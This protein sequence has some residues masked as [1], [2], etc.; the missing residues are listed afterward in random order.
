MKKTVNYVVTL[1]IFCIIAAGSLAFV[2]IYTMPQIN[3]LKEQNT[4]LAVTSVIPGAAEIK[5]EK[6]D[7]QVYFIGMKDGK[8]IGIAIKSTPKGYSAPIQMLVG[9]DAQGNVSGIAI[10]DQKETPGLGANILTKDFK[11]TGK[12]FVDQFIGKNAESILKANQDID[13]LTGATISTNAVC[14]GVRTALKLKQE[15]KP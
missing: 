5:E 3:R 10:L 11:G 2:Y 4:R 9:I 12:A 7:N 1:S 14:E 8:S 15:I 6:I 13:A